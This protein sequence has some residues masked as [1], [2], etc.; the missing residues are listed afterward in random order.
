MI[1][2]LTGRHSSVRPPQFP[3]VVNRDCAQA[4][5]LVAFWPLGYESYNDRDAFSGYDM[6]PAGSIAPPSMSTAAGYGNTRLFVRASGTYLNINSVPVTATP[7]TMSAWVRCYDV[8]NTQDAFSIGD[9]ASGSCWRL[10]LGG[11]TAGKVIRAISN[12]SGNAIASSAAGYAQYGY[13]LVTATFTSPALR[14]AYLDG[15][16]GGSDTTSQAS[17]PTVTRMQIG[18]LASNAGGGNFDGEIVHV[19]LWNRAL[20]DF[21]VG[22]LYDASSR[23]ELY[24]PVGRKTWSFSPAAATNPQKLAGWQRFGMAAMSGLAG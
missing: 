22:K 11:N 9:A 10:N 7:L 8:T 1:G 4:Q 16:N 18:Q 20:S 12:V 5:G 2:I 19:C 17:D 6:T 15:A 14:K 13:H 24:Y 23:W 3:W 21:E